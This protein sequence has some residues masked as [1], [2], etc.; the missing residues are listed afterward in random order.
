MTGVT[1]RATRGRGGEG[2]ARGRAGAAAELSAALARA[3]D[4]ALL[5]GMRRGES[6][7]YEEYLLRFQP[8]LLDQARRARIPGAEREECVLE[9]LSDVA[10]RL[11]LPDAPTPRSLAAYL[12][13][14]F[15]RR[16]LN[17]LRDDA[18]RMRREEAA[19]L[20][21]EEESGAGAAACS[22][23]TRRAS[24]GPAWEE[25]G[26]AP[27]L[28]RLARALDAE[29]TEAERLVLVWVSHHVP[30]REIAA[31]LGV[32]Y[33]AAAQ[34]ICRLRQ[35]L[36]ASAARYVA[37]LPAAERDEIARFLRRAER[38]GASEESSDPP[39]RDAPRGAPEEERHE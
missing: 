30:Q 17:A 1:T 35:R 37:T 7:A 8:I 15:R 33:A 32:S 34:R 2:G 19:S 31:W 12:V 29:L 24:R 11:A 25:V 6:A 39:A 21:A 3:G 5:E 27:A 38:A 20:L 14:S 16:H 22:E 26:P 9:V 36:R 23:G 4:A 10:V 18:R 13:T 28:D